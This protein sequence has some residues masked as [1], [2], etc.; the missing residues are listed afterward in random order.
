MGWEAQHTAL[1]GTDAEFIGAEVRSSSI[2]V[3]AVLDPEAGRL[4]SEL[5]DLLSV[6]ND[7]V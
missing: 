3:R 6:H 7:C 2:C 4:G 5:G 1:Q